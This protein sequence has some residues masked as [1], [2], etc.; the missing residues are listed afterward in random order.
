MYSAQFGF[1]LLAGERV[2][3][4]PGRDCVDWALGC[5]TGT[6]QAVSTVSILHLDP[7]STWRA[8]SFARPTLDLRHA[9]GF[10]VNIS[11]LITICNYGWE[12]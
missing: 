9:A 1:R 11:S 4:V 3:F 8:T 6:D 12:G 10:T 2:S 7:T 5:R